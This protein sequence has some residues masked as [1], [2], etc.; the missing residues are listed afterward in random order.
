MSTE[1]EYKYIGIY[2][3][4]KCQRDKQGGVREGTATWI[5]DYCRKDSDAD[6]SRLSGLQRYILD[7]LRRLRG[8]HGKWPVNDPVMLCR[9]LCLINSDRPHLRRA[10]RVLLQADLLPTFRT[11]L[12]MISAKERGS[13]YVQEQ[14]QRGA[15]DRGAEAAGS[16]A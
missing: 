12:S 5:K 11:K 14:S 7:G 8:L 4:D 6:Y 15:D 9:Q 16:G 2:G 1:Q 10:L 3:Y 13:G